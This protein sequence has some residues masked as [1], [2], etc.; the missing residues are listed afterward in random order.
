MFRFYDTMSSGQSACS[1]IFTLSCSEVVFSGIFL[2]LI[3]SCQ[4][5]SPSLYKKFGDG[6]IMR[7]GDMCDYVVNTYF[8]ES[9][10]GADA[11]VE[12]LKL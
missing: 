3:Y 6:I 4:L 7:F 12:A 1:E 9:T 10:A 8:N 5:Q 2:I 11:S